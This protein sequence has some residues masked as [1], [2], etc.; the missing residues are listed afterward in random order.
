MKSPSARF[1]RG[2]LHYIVSDHQGTVREMLSEEGVLVWAQRLTTWGKA[3]RFQVIASNNPDYHVNC[4]QRF[5]GQFE[6]EE[7]GLYYNRFRYYSP[8]TGQYISPDPIGLL[9]GVNPYGYVHNPTNFIDP[10]GLAPCP[11]PP[12][13]INL[14]KDGVQHVKDRHVGNVPGWS[15]KSKWA[16]NNA[17][18]KSTIRDV[19]RKPDRIIRDGDR[20]IYEKTLKRDVGI[21]PEGEVLNKVRV[22]TESN[23]DLV[24]AF[25]QSVFKDLK[26]TDV[27]F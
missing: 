9:G 3:E 1:E 19:F 2:K 26:P 12:K 11:T 4:N 13:K 10:F 16:L 17:D 22:V 20:F 23:G 8:E 27:I 5:C 6:D 24:T 18:V 25:P 7:S 21:T 15:H 14:T